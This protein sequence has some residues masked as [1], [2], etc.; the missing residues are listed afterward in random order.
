M[1]RLIFLAVLGLAAFVLGSASLFMVDQREYAVVKQIGEIRRVIDQPGLYFKI[2]LIQNITYFDK[3]ILTID[4]ADVDRFITSEKLNVLVDSFVKWRIADPKRFVVSVGGSEMIGADRISRSVRDAMNN[5][6]AK[7]TVSDMISGEREQMMAS[8][9]TKVSEDAKQI[10]AEIIDVRMKRVDFAPE[11]SERVFDRMQAERKRVANE[12][13]AT[14]SAESEK[15]RADADRQREVILAEAYRDAQEIKGEGDAKASA[16]YAQAFGQDPQF[17][18]FYRSL[19]AYRASFR[20]R[21]DLL[22]VD[23]SSDFFKFFR[24]SG[25]RA[26]GTSDGAGQSG[27]KR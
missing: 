8:V 24:S 1:Q 3:R 26:S 15:I 2:P 10:G 16:V 17:A 14:G 11:V 13:R 12:R 21:S 5:E 6:I 4:T 19:E 7:R 27:G 25:G 20:N 18:Q 22:V 23:P 9:R